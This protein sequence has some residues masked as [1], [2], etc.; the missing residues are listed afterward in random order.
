MVLRS[1]IAHNEE[2]ICRIINESISE[3]NINSEDTSPD[4]KFYFFE[5]VLGLIVRGR[6]YNSHLM[7][8]EFSESRHLNELDNTLE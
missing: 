1:L 6:G 3:I 4:V 8:L 5:E 2:F 7:S